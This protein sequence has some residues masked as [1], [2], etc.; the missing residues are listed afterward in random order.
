MDADLDAAPHLEPPLI[1]QLV[2]AKLRDNNV[3]SG[4]YKHVD[5]TSFAAPI[6]S[7]LAAQMLEANPGLAPRQVKRLLVQTARRLSHVPVDRQGWG[8]V[9]ARRA[10]EAAT[11]EPEAAY[12]QKRPGRHWGAPDTVWR[13]IPS[14]GGW[15]F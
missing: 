4:A 8:V 6:V 7:S 1:R 10:L 9:D 15:G 5:G 12:P 2:A 11:R 14:L 13:M 3:I